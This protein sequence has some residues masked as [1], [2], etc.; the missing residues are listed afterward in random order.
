MSKTK[1]AQR[2]GTYDEAAVLAQVHPRTLRR[3]AEAGLLSLYRPPHDERRILLD[4][5]E[6]ESLFSSNRIIE[7]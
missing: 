4:L 2:F 5:N 1:P 3:R 7:L 6:V